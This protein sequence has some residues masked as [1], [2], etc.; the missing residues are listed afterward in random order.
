[1]TYPGTYERTKQMDFDFDIMEDLRVWEAPNTLWF[2]VNT[3]TTVKNISKNY[4]FA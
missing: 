1:M 2:P 4:F 3:T